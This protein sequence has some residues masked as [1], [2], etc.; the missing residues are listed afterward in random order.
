MTMTPEQFHDLLDRDTRLSPPAP[1]DDPTALGRRRLRRRRLAASAGAA[2]TVLVVVGVASLGGHAATAPHGHEA[3]TAPSTDAQLLDACSSGNQGP[4]L[5]RLF[6]GSGT[7]TIEAAVRTDYQWELAI[8][9]ADG[10]FWADC[11]VHLQSSEFASGMTVYD[12]TRT[13]KGLSYGA[14]AACGLVDND[15]D[16]QCQTWSVYTVDRLPSVVAAVRYDLGDGTSVTVRTSNG[17]VVL[18]HLAPLPA[19]VSIQPH[20]GG[21]THFD[22]LTRVTYLDGSGQP[23]AAEAL[24]GPPGEYSV[25][26]LPLLSKYPSLR[27][28]PVS[29]GPRG[30]EDLHPRPPGASLVAPPASEPGT[31]TPAG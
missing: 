6:F 12:A 19:G 1:A 10:H 28:G 9:S 27:S 26:G 23:L 17:Y 16:P 7:P 3:L 29:T 25:D 21:L 4:E 11:F 22:A 2:A 14:G 13:S 15:T 24:N 30:Q 8:Q 18:N 31:A 5:T 20:S